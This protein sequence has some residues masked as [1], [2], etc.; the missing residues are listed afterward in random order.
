[1]EKKEITME[2]FENE[3][4][5]KFYYGNQLPKANMLI[6]ETPWF[7]KALTY[8]LISL[9]IFVLNKLWITWQICIINFSAIYKVIIE[10]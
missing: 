3:V 2:N 1:M 6:S 7:I 5:V 9:H 8:S 4:I 10:T